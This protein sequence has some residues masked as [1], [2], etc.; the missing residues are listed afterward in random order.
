MFSGGGL[1]ELK[2]WRCDFED[3]SAQV[4]PSFSLLD[5]IPKK[6]FTK[7]DKI[8]TEN[9]DHNHRIMTL[10]SFPVISNGRGIKERFF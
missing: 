7:A 3:I 4:L 1:I 6:K 8:Q 5:Q 2:A 9:K 10:T